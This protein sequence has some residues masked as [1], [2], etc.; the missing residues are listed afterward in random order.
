MRGC[1]AGQPGALTWR[2]L[3]PAHAG[4]HRG[5]GSSSAHERTVPRACGDA[6]PWVARIAD[7]DGC[8]PRMRGCT[9]VGVSGVAV[10]MLFPAHAGMHRVQ[11]PRQL[12]VRSVPRA[13]G[14]APP[15]GVLTG[16]PLRCSP[17]MRGCTGGDR[18][19]ARDSHLFPAHA[20]M[21]RPRRCPC[22]CGLTVPR[23]CGDAPRCLDAL[24][25][26]RA[27]SPRMRGCTGRRSRPPAPR[28][29]FPAHAGMHRSPT[30]RRSHTS[31]VPRACGDAP[32]A[33]TPSCPHPT[34]SPRMRGCT[35]QRGRSVDRQA[36]FPAHAGMHRCRRRTRCRTRS[37]PRACGDAPY[38]RS[39]IPSSAGCSPRM[40]GCTEHPRPCRPRPR[41][42]PAHA[43]MHRK[44]GRDTRRR[45]PVP[46]ACGD[47]PTPTPIA[48]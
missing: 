33:A 32:L 34:C 44:M 11:P 17:R 30:L 5:N 14:D 37:V 29:L 40:R 38:A 35:A 39:S 6:P 15:R 46:R 16:L 10:P 8:S 1:T 18:R 41:L 23:A 2:D 27:C 42:F 45:R 12:E 9:V 21:H 31:P 13:C 7:A 24:D 47:A 3:F 26:A 20:G 4:M 36:L 19:R 22:R 43:G 25:Q 28:D 48:F